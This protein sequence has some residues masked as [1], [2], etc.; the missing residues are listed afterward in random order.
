[1]IRLVPMTEAEFEPYIEW[2]S[3]AYARDQ[4]GAGIWEEDGAYQ[5]AAASLRR[6]LPEGLATPGNYL[7][8]V[9]DDAVT[10]PVG[11]VWLAVNQEAEPAAF[12]MDIEIYAAYQRRG[13]AQAALQA[14]E[15]QA[16]ALGISKIGLNVH[17]HN[18]GAQALYE[19]QGYAVTE[20]T[21][22]KRLE[23]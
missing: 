2:L 6:E 9:R 12:I 13:Y 20:H 15:D 5:R 3:A 8:R 1:M 11:Q 17:A 16:R 10:E 14:L 7:Y 18:H 23:P 4:I 19:K 21:M 22:L